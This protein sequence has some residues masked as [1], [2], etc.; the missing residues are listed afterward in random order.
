MKPSVKYNEFMQQSGFFP[1]QAQQHALYLL[2]RL[3][4]NIVKDGLSEQ[5][6][7]DRISTFFG[8]KQSRISSTSFLLFLFR[9]Y[10][11]GVEWGAAK[12]F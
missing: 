6:I 9:D 4:E 8:L 7:I 11:F 3:Y 2:D 12:H 5:G 10:I 1:D